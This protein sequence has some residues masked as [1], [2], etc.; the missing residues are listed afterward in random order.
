MVD[1]ASD[2]EYADALANA[3][4]APLP[5]ISENFSPLCSGL[6][7]LLLCHQPQARW[8]YKWFAEQGR[9]RKLWWTSLQSGVGHVCPLPRLYFGHLMAVSNTG[10]LT[11]CLTPTRQVDSPSVQ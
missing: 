10:A 1:L 8:Y 4:G 2:K 3:V 7:A 9:D 6:S 5:V 11:A